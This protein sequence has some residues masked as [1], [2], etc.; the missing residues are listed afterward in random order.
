MVMLEVRRFLFF[1]INWT[2]VK[3][4]LCGL[5]TSNLTDQ[6]GKKYG[7]YKDTVEVVDLKKLAVVTESTLATTR[8]MV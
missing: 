6:N 2:N 7:L 8:Y 4:F 1:T 5:E 3:Q